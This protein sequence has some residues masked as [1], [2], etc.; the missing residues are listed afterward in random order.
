VP[1]AKVWRARPHELVQEIQDLKKEVSRLFKSVEELSIRMQATYTV[2]VQRSKTRMARVEDL[3]KTHKKDEL[4]R[5]MLPF[6][7]G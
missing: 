3:F 4:H 1:R 2:K 6:C 7:W 5:P